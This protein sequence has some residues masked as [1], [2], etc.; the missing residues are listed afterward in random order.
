VFDPYNCS[1]PG[2][3][4]KGRPY[5][6]DFFFFPAVYLVDLEDVLDG[7]PVDPERITR[8]ITFF[9]QE[10]HI[11]SLALSQPILQMY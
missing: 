7:V 9:Y 4:T 2:R 11:D 5:F 10:H 3:K 8:T 6:G 1:E